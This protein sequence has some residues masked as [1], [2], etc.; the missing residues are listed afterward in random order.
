MKSMNRQVTKFLRKDSGRASDVAVL[1]SEYE[2]ADRVLTKII[3]SSKAWRDSWVSILTFQ[4]EM[5]STFSE[6]YNPIVGSSDGHGQEPKITPQEQLDGTRKLEAAYADLRSELQQE[7]E[8][9]DSRIISP[10]ISIKEYMQPLKKTIKKRE[11]KRLD[12]EMYT[13]RVNGYARKMRRT[14]SDNAALA[15]AEQNMAHAANAFQVIDDHLREILPPIISAAFSILPHLLGAQIL[16]QHALLA[17][18][19]TALQNYCDE[20]NFLEQSSPTEDVSTVWRTKFN[21]ALEKTKPLK[22]IGRGRSANYPKDVTKK[23]PGSSMVKSPF[24]SVKIQRPSQNL[25]AISQHESTL[26]DARIPRISSHQSLT[27]ASSKSSR[28]PSNNDLRQIIPVNN[29][30]P[31]HSI[32]KSGSLVS[33]IKKK[34]KP[35]PPPPKRIGLKNPEIFA[36]AL[37]SFEGQNDGDLSFNDGDQIKILKKTNSTDDWW[38]GELR[39][40]QGSI[41][42]NYFKIC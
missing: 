6:I 7:I 8:M 19:Y 40:K 9:I 14:D 1:L 39:G 28:C 21:F 10:A 34:K 38:V 24:T 13:D 36:T 31:P 18:Y 42:A 27:T 30:L 41:P 15:K 35:P 17:L 33:E 26:H 11:N 16:I 37:Y 23:D 4:K 20:T 22:C 32:S 12:W 29:S 3:E 25:V 5:T 2:E